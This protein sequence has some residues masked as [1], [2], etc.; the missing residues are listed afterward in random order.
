MHISD[1]TRPPTVPSRESHE[2][3][4]HFISRQAFEA[5]IASD[6]FVEFG[7][8]EN[9]FF[10]TSMDAIRQ[11]VNSGKICVLSFHPQVINKLW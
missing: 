9:H 8:F 11:V 10:G 3:D 6:K 1:T 4:Y 7:E 2:S 5:D